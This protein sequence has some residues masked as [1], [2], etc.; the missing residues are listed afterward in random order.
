MLSSVLKE[1]EG[2][3]LRKYPAYS[4]KPLGGKP[5]FL[6]AL[7]GALTEEE[8]P[9][10]LE[11]INSIKYL[12]SYA[13]SVAELKKGIEE[14]LSNVPKNDEDSRQLGAD[15]RIREVRASWEALFT[16][17]RMREFRILR[18]RVSCGTGAYMR[19][20]AGRIGE[21]FGTKGL[22]LSINRTKLGRQWNGVWLR[23]Y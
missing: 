3:H 14:F 10:H 5:L 23:S 9:E 11:V 6:R 22:A 16:D 21:A 1:E 8:I 20:L 13:L 15:F 2:A 4:S 18:L 12:G 17:M 19:T 7:T